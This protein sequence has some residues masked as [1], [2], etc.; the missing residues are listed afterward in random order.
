MPNYADV[1]GWFLR[2]GTMSILTLPFC[3]FFCVRHGLS[4]VL[5]LVAAVGWAL[6]VVLWG[7]AI[8]AE[9]HHHHGETWG[10]FLQKEVL[11]LL[12]VVP[13]AFLGI[14]GGVIVSAGTSTI[15]GPVA[16][17]ATGMSWGA[18]LNGVI[19]YGVAFGVKGALALATIPCGWML[20][21]EDQ[22]L[23]EW[24]D[25]PHFMRHHAQAEFVAAVQAVKVA[26]Q[27]IVAQNQARAEANALC[28]REGRRG[29]FQPLLGEQSPPQPPPT[30]TWEGLCLK[31]ILLVVEGSIAA[32]IVLA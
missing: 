5:A 26:N 7:P 22:T 28:R 9:E 19:W 13:L 14:V 23:R 1:L 20:R 30:C 10:T 11:Y 17:Q 15:L 6:T 31:V 32:V 24:W 2:I 18:A 21:R 3:F 25:A 27:G 16:V 12:I 8:K 29:E 4:P